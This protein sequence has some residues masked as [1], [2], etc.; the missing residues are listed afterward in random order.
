MLAINKA[1]NIIV[2]NSASLTVCTDSLSSLMSIQNKF[3]TEPSI[4]DI[5][6]SLKN[7]RN[8]GCDV[9]F[10]WVPSHCGITGN[11]KADIAAKE[12][13]IDG[14]RCERVELADLIAFVKRSVF[15]KWDDLWSEVTDNK[16]KRIK[17]HISSWNSSFR[18]SRREEV[19]LT[20][21]RIGHTRLT[22]GHLMAREPPPVCAECEAQLTV[23][24]ILTE[25][26]RYRQAR[27]RHNINAALPTILGN[28]S[29]LL[30]NLFAYL[31]DIGVYHEI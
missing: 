25:C 7:L 26:R 2:P 21:L 28:E 3:A 24:H 31:R 22:H 6:Y 4:L 15:K 10:I 20:R 13:I 9:K 12:A 8:E 19:V 1:L 30:E 29:A 17:A 18:N 23:E 16:L 14:D 11:E 5:L 27:A